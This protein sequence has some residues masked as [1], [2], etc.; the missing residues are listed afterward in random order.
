MTLNIS[1]FG[2]TCP[3]PGYL[4][5]SQLLNAPND[6]ASN[7]QTFA[8][9]DA[10][11]IP[12]QSNDYLF[13]LGLYLDL[14]F[15]DA[16]TGIWRVLPDCSFRPGMQYIKS[17]GV[18][19]RIANRL[20]CPVSAIVANGGS[21]FTQATAT[22]TANVGGSTW[23]PVIG[24]SLTVTS[25]TAV[26]AHYSVAPLVLIPS[27]TPA[28]VNASVGGIAATAYATL[29]N[30]TVS[31]VTMINFGAGYQSAPGALLVPSPFDPNFGIIT[32]AAVT[33]GI[34]ANTTGAIT[35]A[36]CTNF[37]APLATLSALTLTAGG[38]GTGATI[39]PE[40]LQTIASV[41]VVA[42]GAG[43]GTASAFPT[44][45]SNGGGASGTAATNLS[46]PSIDFSGFV[47]RQAQ[48]IATTNAGGTVTS[49]TVLDGGMFLSTPTAAIASG[50]TLPT[51]LAS[52]TFVMGTSPGTA[53]LQNL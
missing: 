2:M 20:G 6:I 40:I 8:P 34:N 22:L 31:G 5:P 3:P 28:G 53:L 47:P 9:G 12:A 32:P 29:A 24:G 46:N 13:D 51:T 44:V 39:T 45:S 25:V 15:L 27:P 35:G 36:L 43:F 41:S 11:Y 4:Y 48:L 21:G 19:R 16:V 7:L 10:L 17:N 26:G 38:T 49:V 14:E 23:V 52:I 42:G 37:G 1:G 33:L 50:G 18:D 30:G